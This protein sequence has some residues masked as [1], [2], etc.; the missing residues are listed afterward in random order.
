[1]EA[2]LSQGLLVAGIIASAL[3]LAVVYL[4]AKTVFRG[5]ADGYKFDSEGPADMRA[6]KAGNTGWEK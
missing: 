3:L 2:V 1:M 6:Y 4:A 5:K